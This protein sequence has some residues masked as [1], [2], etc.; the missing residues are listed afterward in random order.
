M[1]P[2]AVFAA[3][4]AVAFALLSLSLAARLRAHLRELPQSLLFTLIA[5]LALPGLWP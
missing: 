3:A 4:L 2:A 1:R 5:G